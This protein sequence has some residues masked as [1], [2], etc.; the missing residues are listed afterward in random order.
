M[1]QNGRDRDARLRPVE[2]LYAG[3][4]LSFQLE[5]ASFM[6][7]IALVQGLLMVFRVLSLPKPH[8]G[9]IPH[10]SALP[11]GGLPKMDARSEQNWL[12]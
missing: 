4:L 9:N 5:N 1:A 6:A 3:G 2:V 12:N 7:A 10:R 8:M 11:P